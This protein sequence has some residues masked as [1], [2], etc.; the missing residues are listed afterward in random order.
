MA[1]LSARG[2]M[3]TELSSNF[4]DMGPTTGDD[5]VAQEINTKIAETMLASDIE[6]RLELNISIGLGFWLSVFGYRYRQLTTATPNPETAPP[7]EL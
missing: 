7:D 4:S 2:F 1:G 6:Y 5:A 3:F